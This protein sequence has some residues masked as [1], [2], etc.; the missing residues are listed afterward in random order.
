M[1]SA[2]VLS[3]IA[4][5]FLSGCDSQEVIRQYSVPK[6]E[7][8]GLSGGPIDSVAQSESRKILGAIVPQE[9]EVWFFKLFDA[10]EKVEQ[11]TD[12]FR[13]LVNELSFQEGKPK[14]KLPEK[15]S[16]ETGGQFVFANLRPPGEQQLK[17][18]VSPLPLP[19]EA[20]S[21][22]EKSWRE[23]V[24]QNVNRWRGQLQL[25]QLSWDEIVADL[26]PIDKLSKPKT[27]AYFV[28]LRGTSSG[29]P[30]MGMGGAGMGM[31]A[32]ASS[33]PP[34]SSTPPMAS[35]KS[36]K[37]D[38]QFELPSG[39]Q[40]VA[41]LNVI[42]LHS[43]EADAPEGAKAKVTITAAGGD[44]ESNV[45]RWAGQVGGDKA[46]AKKALEAAE[47]FVVNEVE[48]EVVQL[49]GPNGEAITAAMVQWDTQNTLF[50]KLYGPDAAVKPNYDA[51][52]GFVKS[53]RW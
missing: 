41:P 39:W 7:T 40:A 2:A 33:A 47:K 10:P 26:E 50:V 9:N 1:V 22:D 16:E 20:S 24:L 29:G 35:S 17:V 13:Q 34:P 25:N 42:A 23:F 32:G 21:M 53:L 15:W 12:D 8:S 52:V 36:S 48:A 6:S 49:V 37:R 30:G 19:V 38:I 11:Y 5:F 28:T 27:P 44:R 18:S 4:M 3:L 31:G 46:L 14:W 45:E 51:F 43:F